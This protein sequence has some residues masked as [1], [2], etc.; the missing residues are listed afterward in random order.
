MPKLSADGRY[1]YFIGHFEESPLVGNLFRIDLSQNSKKTEWLT[2][3]IEYYY[4]YDDGRRIIFTDA[5]IDSPK[6]HIYML[7]TL[8]KEEKVL[9]E[10]R[11]SLFAISADVTKI[12]Y[13]YK[14]ENTF[15]VRIAYLENDSISN[16]TTIYSSG[17]NE[18][19]SKAF[20]N[21]DGSKIIVQG[22][23][24]RNYVIELRYKN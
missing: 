5:V 17:T 7:D 11:I 14:N 20:W 22:G 8:T 15:E 13:A 3:H 24:G 23:L 4:L 6:R 19:I 10:N 1:L 16:S 9:I 21:Y 18:Y 12:V 2:D